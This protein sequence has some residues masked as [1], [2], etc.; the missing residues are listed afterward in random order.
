MNMTFVTVVRAALCCA[1]SLA[2]SASA[3]DVAAALQ[4]AVLI[5]Q[6]EGDLAAAEQAYRAVLADVP[7]DAAA[8]GAEAALRLGEL[9]WRLE[10]RD[11]AAPFLQQ[12]Q[13]AGGDVGARAGAVLEGRAGAGQD[14]AIAERV[15][16]LL[17][18]ALLQNDQAVR[19]LRWLG[20]AAVPELLRQLEA[21]R[22][23]ATAHLQAA[24]H[25][26]GPVLH[27]RNLTGAQVP[28]AVLQLRETLRIGALVWAIGGDEARRY[29]QSVTQESD[30]NWRLVCAAATYQ[31]QASADLQPVVERFLAD[32]DPQVAMELLGQ[33][34]S[35]PVDGLPGVLQQMDGAVRAAAW[36]ALRDCVGL[37]LQ[38]G[39]AR[40]RTLHALLPLVARDLE[41][42]QP[43]LA[44]EA[45]QFLVV[46]GRAVAAGME[47]LL[48]WL[49]R[50]PVFQPPS[51]NESGGQ[52]S[53][54]VALE[55]IARCARA[56][57]AWDD[58]SDESRRQKL[59][60][61]QS[62][63]GRASLPAE[64]VPW[65]LDLIELGYDNGFLARA[66]QAAERAEDLIR[67]AGLLGQVRDSKKCAEFLAERDLPP[68]AAAPIAARLRAL[69]PGLPPPSALPLPPDVNAAVLEAHAL[70]AALARTGNPEAVAT[71]R[72]AIGP[73][74]ID[75]VA[76]CAGD[77]SERTDAPEVR[78]LVRELLVSERVGPVV[79]NRLFGELVRCGDAA[80]IPLLP[81][82]YA[83]GLQPQKKGEPVGCLWLVLDKDGA[84]SHGYDL[85][86]QL[87]AWQALLDGPAWVQTLVDLEYGG[88]RLP[89]PVRC[90][91]AE[92]LAAKADLSAASARHE[93]GWA[94]C[95]LV[96][97][98]PAGASAV[99][100]RYREAVAALCAGPFGEVAMG[101]M[102][103]AVTRQL[104]DR[105]LPLLDG[106][107]AVVAYRTLREAGIE[108][109]AARVAALLRNGNENAQ[110][111]LLD[112][113]PQEP[114][115]EI[116]RA[117]EAMIRDRD[118]P[119]REKACETLG[120]LLAIDSTGALLD[121]MRDVDDG[122][123]A[124]AGAAMQAI[125][126]YHEQR[127]WLAG[128]DSGIATGRDQV[129]AKLL[130]QARPDQPK[131]Q[132]LLALRSLGD[133][134]E[135]LALPYLI[136]WC[137]DAD[138]EVA[139]AAR[140][141]IDR[142]HRAASTGAGGVD[143]HK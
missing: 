113:L 21:R 137:R 10:R 130:L 55:H 143:E 59:Y 8:L 31:V 126:A 97:E 7:T 6:R 58:G 68:A 1:F 115:A 136:D 104:A 30:P 111:D 54:S 122:V 45:F 102:P 127:A 62:C 133:L 60:F 120:R 64:D 42:P 110:R 92:I 134:G 14:P 140:A 63:V 118:R 43:T 61:V 57:G 109:P 12:A 24:A 125:R 141:A 107:S 138:T 9:L 93:A 22:A 50:V 84:A 139:A 15:R 116:L 106:E 66:I 25:P 88:R 34:G 105:L 5:E 46:R 41:S 94:V 132:R 100:V 90:A 27:A 35:L 77:L 47:L 131:D 123:R 49:P 121:A 2:G 4:R 89:L 95:S 99:E 20:G 19:D 36:G 52:A 101:P 29:L 124:A 108:V 117:V 38:P 51:Q 85:P 53:A 40:D 39:S 67:A 3:Q 48:E 73:R 32:R 96:D 44:R 26:M 69:L 79:R 128:K 86:Q 16:E 142:I 17:P 23:E 28:A 91:I 76:W 71:L 13:A 37:L 112:L 70:F 129:A 114:G 82:A 18:L 56:L 75:R 80:A 78:A 83:L 65:L 87:A 74:W 81:R 11:E 119:T 135:A 98:T 103:I 72:A 33:V